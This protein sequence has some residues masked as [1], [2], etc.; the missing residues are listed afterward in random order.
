ME[1]YR[2]SEVELVKLI[3]DR[4]IE[5]A[6]QYINKYHFRS[7]AVIYKKETNGYSTY[8]TNEL[9]QLMPSDAILYE[10]KYKAFS[11]KDY[12]ATSEFMDLNYKP[13]IDFNR[14]ELF[15][16]E[17]EKIKRKN[18]DGEEIEEE[19]ILYYLNMAKPLGIKLT[20]EVKNDKE[21]REKLRTI[22][23]H[24]RNI[25]CS[26]NDAMFEYFMNFI[27]C[28]FGGRKL[29]KAI[30]MQSSE[31]TGKGI[32]TNFIGS[33]L[34]ERFLCVSSA[35]N[36]VKYTSEW[37]GRQLVLIDEP[38]DER[39]SFHSISDPL[40]RLITEPTFECR[41]MYKQSYMQKNT[42]NIWISTN[43]N[44][45][46]FTQTNKRRYVCLDI[47]NAMV[48][49]KEYFVEL[50]RC[51]RD[52]SVQRAFYE[53]M[54][55]RFK[56]LNN[57]N[58]DD[59]PESKQTKLKQIEALPRFIKYLKQKYVLE[60]KDIC[61]ITG[62]FYDD[63]I[64]STQDKYTSKIAINKYFKDLGFAYTR[65]S[66]HNYRYIIS[67]EDL[68]EAF[69]KKHWID[70]ETDHVVNNDYDE[71]KLGSECEKILKKKDPIKA[72][73][74]EEIQEMHNEIKS[75]VKRMEKNNKIFSEIF[76]KNKKF[77]SDNDL[78]QFKSK[79]STWIDSLGI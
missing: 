55:E 29:R 34:G 12:V 57:W 33:V 30:Y 21:T 58:E 2:F 6:K 25:L 71:N 5:E 18:E 28:T 32:F 64:E 17:K 3:K 52:E 7:D 8:K 60:K 9:K 37:E 1:D 76:E 48:G 40:K 35:E 73:T 15:Y 41:C 74:I 44:A 22:L 63:Y 54:I 53:I 69:K 75:L 19:N 46:S 11:A 42:F 59:V 65:T 20:D 36:V 45:I 61:Q 51:M 13:T 26:R 4:K 38:C 27:A 79:M 70:E 10:G 43:N 23:N 78:K 77:E 16:T 49:N 68:Y 31:G 56:D 66:D 62:D 72:I 24:V 67:H 39:I 50:E 47:S 14:K